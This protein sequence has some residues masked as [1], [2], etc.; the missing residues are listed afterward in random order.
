MNAH[1][2]PETEEAIRSRIAYFRDL[3]VFDFYRREGSAPGD[4]QKDT[5]TCYR[6]DCGC[7][8]NRHRYRR[9]SRGRSAA[10]F[11]SDEDL[12]TAE[13]MSPKQARPQPLPVLNEP[14]VAVAPKDRAAA[15]AAIRVRDRRLYPL[16][17]PQGPAHGCVW[18]RRSE[19]PPHVRGRRSRRRR[20]RAGAAL[21]G[22]RRPAAQQHDRRDGP[23]PRPGLHREHRQMPSAAESRSG[24]GR[25]QHLRAVS[26]SPDRCDP[27]GG[28]RRARLNRGHVSAGRQEPA[29]GACAD[30]FITRA[31][32][33]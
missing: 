4:W 14:S 18:R 5:K 16:R 23:A 27:P 7:I 33:S 20:R 8:R 22:S 26:V 31:D 32:R 11:A 17:P 2:S 13:E 25:G 24:T 1:L 28:D 15:L 19:R 6:N 9:R 29:R 12:E 3:G 10:V 30:A 21:R